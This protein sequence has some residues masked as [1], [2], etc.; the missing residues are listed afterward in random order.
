[1]ALSIDR[2]DGPEPHVALADLLIEVGRAAFERKAVVFLHID[3]VQNITDD[4]TL[5]QLLVALGDVLGFEFDVEAPGGQ[6][7]TRYLPVVVYLTGLPEFED[8]ADTR[9]G[10]TFSRRFAW[11]RLDPLDDADIVAALDEF[12][13]TGWEVVDGDG[14]TGTVTM[15]QDAVDAIIRACCGDPFLF[16]L[17]GERAWDASASSLITVDDVGAGW[18]TAIQEA[19]R[20]VDRILDRLPDR[21]RQ[22]IDIMAGL[23]PDDRTLTRIATDLG[24]GSAAQI[25]TTARRLDSVRG[26]IQRGGGRGRPC[27]F[28]HRAVEAYL[29]SEWPELLER[30]VSAP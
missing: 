18:S 29:T 27:R 23:A 1:M 20:H 16:Q 19:E 6:M 26:L 25:A 3:E 24:Y 8:N 14:G 22:F 11:Q 15:A 21:E 5:S 13:T 28:R 17:A 10:A 12:V 7:I 9:Q 30:D 2:R 4:R